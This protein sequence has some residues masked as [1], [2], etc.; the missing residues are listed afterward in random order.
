MSEYLTLRNG[1]KVLLNTPE[2]DATITAAA[3]ED[4]DAAPYTDEEWE[5]IKPLLRC[6]IAEVTQERITIHL[7]R[8]VVE[9]FRATGPGW[10]RRMDAAL[11]D[12]LEQHT[13]H[14]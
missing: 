7:S 2:E 8:H 11:A 12:W 4:P 10:Q 13:P 1:R 3:M 9:R 5:Q 6:P 14:G